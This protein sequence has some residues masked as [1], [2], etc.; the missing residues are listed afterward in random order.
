MLPLPFDVESLLQPLS[1]AEPSGGDCVYE[2]PFAAL[3]QAV[4]GKP[5]RQYGDKVYPAEPPDW[6]TIY[7]QAL[8]LAGRTRDLRVGVWLLRSATRQYG[9]AG[10]AAGLMLLGGL[11]ERFWPSV[12]P[13]LDASEANDPTM[14]LNALLPLAADEA[15]SADLRSAALGSTRG[16]LTLRELQ[17]GLRKAEPLPDE[18]QPTEAGV[19]AALSELRS[20]QPELPRLAEAAL[21]A[22]QA[23]DATLTQQVGAAQAIDLAPVLRLLKLL[24]ATLSGRPTAEENAESASG[25]AGDSVTSTHGAGGSIRSRADAIR[26]LERVCVWLEQH[27]PANPAPLLIRRAQRLMNKSFMEIIRD[28]APDG[29]AQVENLAGPEPGSA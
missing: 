20:R 8:V 16:S 25:E 23:I 24:D 10:A 7:E 12:H 18:P 2:A 22:A 3:E 4:A 14:R 21:Q 13:Q 15:F 6:S 28:L 17:L 19:T 29:V 9:V 11:L 5:E 1:E 27:E 26:E